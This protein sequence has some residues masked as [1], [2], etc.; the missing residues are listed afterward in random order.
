MK[1][2]FNSE[3]FAL[4]SMASHF[5][6]QVRITVDVVVGWERPVFRRTRWAKAVFRHCFAF[7]SFRIAPLLSNQQD[8]GNKQHT[9]DTRKSSLLPWFIQTV[10]Q[11][12][13]KVGRLGF[14]VPLLPSFLL[15]CIFL[16]NINVCLCSFPAD[17][18]FKINTIIRIASV[19]RATLWVV[20]TCH[21]TLTE[22]QLVCRPI[23][24]AVQYG[25]FQHANSSR[26]L[27]AV[28]VL[29][30]SGA[31]GEHTSS[32]S[33]KACRVP[34][35]QAIKGYSIVIVINEILTLKDGVIIRC[36]AVWVALAI[37][38][39]Y[40]ISKRYH[41]LKR[42]I[43]LPNCVWA[44]LSDVSARNKHQIIWIS[45][46]G[47]ARAKSSV[48]NRN[49]T[50]FLGNRRVALAV[51]KRLAEIWRINIIWCCYWYR[52]GWRCCGWRC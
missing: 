7:Q 8:G 20:E 29:G 14:L 26:L 11:E 23:I 47:G 49:F 34:R 30:N 12:C 40:I 33:T 43:D 25:T 35:K 48:E 2:Q 3:G 50:V 18:R 31:I 27:P 10:F 36:A 16:A 44:T 4:F 22:H 46:C 39:S 9:T 17:V 24:N 15:L 6:V 5:I 41:A 38:V 13:F 51:Q 19:S 21:A 37:F 32:C 45:S 52:C 42:S 28:T 1:S